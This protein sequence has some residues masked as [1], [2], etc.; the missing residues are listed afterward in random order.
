LT[1]KHT[2]FILFRLKTEWLYIVFKL[3]RLAS[4]TPCVVLLNEGGCSL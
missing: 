3:Y 1:Q 2:G 4:R